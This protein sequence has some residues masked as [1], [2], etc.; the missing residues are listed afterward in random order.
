M[1]PFLVSARIGDRPVRWA[2]PDVASGDY[3]GRERT[4]EVFRVASGERRDL[5]RALRPVRDAIEAVAG[6]PV[7]VIFHTPRE[8]ERLYSCFLRA[9]EEPAPLARTEAGVPHIDSEGA[10]IDEA[11]EDG[12]AKP[13]RSISRA[14]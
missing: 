10:C 5:L 7:V 12:Q 4:L 14:A 8:S 13:H 6:G 3:D 2:P 11:V 9:F 1:V